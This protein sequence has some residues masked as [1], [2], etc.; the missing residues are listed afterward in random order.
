MRINSNIDVVKP[1]RVSLCTLFLR[2]LITAICVLLAA[3]TTIKQSETAVPIVENAKP[4]SQLVN[5]NELV[6]SSDYNRAASL[7]FQ[8]WGLFEG[9]D[10][11]DVSEYFDRLFTEDVHLKLGEMDINGIQALKKVYASLPAGIDSAH[12]IED[13]RVR[14]IGDDIYS[15]EADF[16]Y[17]TRLPSGEVT[18]TRMQYNHK[19]KKKDGDF[20]LLDVSATPVSSIESPTFKPVY[21][22]NRARA[23]IIQYLGIT[24]DLS[25]DY[26][27]LS[28]LMSNET[29]IH[30]MFD[31][32]KVTFNERGDGV[33]IGRDEIANWLSSRKNSFVR[34][35]HVL[36]DISITPLGDNRIEALATVTTQAWPLE[37]EHIRVDLPVKITLRDTGRQFMAIEK[38]DR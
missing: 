14:F 30:G 12:H 25:S 26:A 17:H 38:I 24:D 5:E 15:L 34:V 16:V 3:C 28:Q 22:E 4:K 9:P 37:G 27:Q 13:I 11:N 31:P 32:A 7:L 8:W 21:R 2:S 19:I 1:L 36:A 18:A 20:A 29:E 6:S 33:L 23:A 35:S 10:G